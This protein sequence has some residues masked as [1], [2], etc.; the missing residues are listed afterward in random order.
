MHPSTLSAADF[1]CGMYVLVLC[2]RQNPLLSRIW[3]HLPRLEKIGGPSAFAHLD[4]SRVPGK[5]RGNAAR[6]K[7]FLSC[8]GAFLCA[9][10][11]SL[12]ADKKEPPPKG[13]QLFF[14]YFPGGLQGQAPLR[15]MGVSAYCCFLPD[16]TRFTGLHCAGPTLAVRRKNKSRTT[17]LIG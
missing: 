10:K 6:T 12:T 9:G 5:N 2:P 11:K 1:D 13:R 4:P 8:I 17:R 16:L 15:H 3:A 14:L 7:S